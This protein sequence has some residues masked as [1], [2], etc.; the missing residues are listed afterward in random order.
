MYIHTVPGPKSGWGSHGLSTSVMPASGDIDADAVAL[1]AALS[2][3]Q[4]KVNSVERYGT[5]RR[6]AKLGGMM[7]S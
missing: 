3:A 5:T 7:T 6:V 1:T 2:N 4:S